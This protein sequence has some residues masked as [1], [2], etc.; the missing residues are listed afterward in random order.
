MPQMP[1]YFDHSATTPVWPEVVKAMEPYFRQGYGNPSS[2]HAAGRKAHAGLQS[3]R[4]KVARLIGA[5]PNEIVFTSGGTESDNAA[6]R[7]IALARREAGA[8]PRVI[9]TPIEH[10]AV[11]ETLED[12]TE[13]HGFQVDLLP[14]D[15]KG[16]VS[17]A[18]LDSALEE[19]AALVSVMLANN[20]VGTLQPLAELGAVCRARRTPLHTD[21]VQALCKTPVQIDDLG[22]A[23]LSAS[24]HKFHGPKGV[25]FLF[26]RR[27][28]P[29]RPRQTGGGHERGRRA[30]TENVPLIHGMAVAMEMNLK[31]ADTE[32]P[33]QR[34]LRDQLI[35]GVLNGVRDAYL[36]GHAEQRLP[37]HASFVV[38]GLEAES[39]LIG[40][41]MAG[42]MASSGSACTSGAQQ[43]S[44]V[45]SALGIEAPDSYG[46]LRFSLGHGTSED[47]V[48]Y[49]VE[50]LSRIAGQLR[51]TPAAA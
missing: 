6:L 37:N 42:I 48:A 14:V 27:G 13:V 10:H 29:F 43:P 35:S 32:W 1:L 17:P 12:L 16:R 19:P 31:S 2:I 7:G 28:T 49:A 8:P 11:L 36:T 34:T 45:L 15:D 46:A 9:S 51:E 41:D 33:R 50:Q 26:L 25:G 30:G 39:M 5:D 47:D 20:E 3:A 18:D 4:G 22:V 44:H 38:P 23:A 24:A 21:A 40:L